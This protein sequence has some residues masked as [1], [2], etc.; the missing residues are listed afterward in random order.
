MGRGKYESGI[1][2]E[3]PGY[4]VAMKGRN[5]KWNFDIEQYFSIRP[6]FLTTKLVCFHVLSR[7]QI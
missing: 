3:R 5:K 2:D 6:D 4:E 7:I 1:S